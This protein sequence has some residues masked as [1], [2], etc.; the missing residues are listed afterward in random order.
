MRLV[1]AFALSLLAAASVAQQPD[2]GLLKLPMNSEAAHPP[3]AAVPAYAVNPAELIPPGD[4]W[5]RGGQQ[6][7]PVDALQPGR[8]YTLRVRV[9]D[10]KAGQ[11]LV[12]FREPKQGNAY[13]TYAKAISGPGEVAIDFTAPAYLAMGEVAISGQGLAIDGVSLKMRAPIPVT[14]PVKSW[15]ESYTP[16]G[17]TLVFNDEF[18]GSAL[19]RGKWITRYIYNGP[20]GGGTLDRLNDEKQ[21]YA[22]KDNH[23]EADGLLK[24]VARRLP[25]EQPK[26]LNYQSGMIRSDWTLRYGFLEARVKMPGGLGV[27]PAFWLNSDVNGA[28]GRLSWPPEIDIFEFVNNGQNDK[29]NQLHLAANTPKG[30]TPVW[31][32]TDPGFK[33]VHQIWV[34]SF[35]FDKGWHTIGLEWMPDRI[36]FYVDGLNVMSRKH[37]WTYEDGSV[38]APAHILLNLAIGGQW[39]GRF[40]IDDAAFPQSLDI[41]WVRAY[42]KQ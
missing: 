34:A 24:L 10:G 38:G 32:H 16:P 22:D 17:Y 19:D 25:G 40:G 1:T 3:T 15:S 28:D 7:L 12:R 18:D 6:K 35:D 2:P 23:V 37:S 11:A 30:T 27:W 31:L 21:R 4:W 20:E 33:P 26:G 42:Q 8:S 39:A 29:V 5:T 14:Q 36:T 41:D 9:G 13:R